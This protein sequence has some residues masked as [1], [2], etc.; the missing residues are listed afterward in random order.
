MRI[1]TRVSGAVSGSRCGQSGAGSRWTRRVAGT[2]VAILALSVAGCAGGRGER[3]SREREKAKVGGVVLE[4]ASEAAWSDGLESTAGLQPLRRAMPGTILMGRVSEILHKEGDRVKAGEVLA[5]IESRDVQARLAQ[6]EAAVSAARAQ[7]LNARL[8]RDRIQRLHEHNATSQK[9]LDDANAGCE[10]AEAGLRAAEEGVEAA[11]IRVGYSNITAPF[12]GVV[13]ERHVEAGDTASPGMPLFVVEDTRKLK[14]EAS[15]PESWLDK[16][17]VG[18]E[19][20]VVVDAAGG[21]VRRGTISEILPSVDP[22]TRTFTLRVLLDNEDGALRSGLFARLR[23]GGASRQAL[24]V[25]ESSL[26]RRGPLAGIFVVDEAG[27]AHLR[28]ITLGGTR[29]GRVEVLTG[30]KDGERYIVAPPPELEDGMQV[31]AK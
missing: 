31:E 8:T 10:A 7:A 19:T 23:I 25:P 27:S 15:V 22:R 1:Q 21:L 9:S 13:A 20:E 26:V 28:W 3:V 6:A 30:L 29:A 12:A 4:R 24:A 5:R 2:G 18:S 11:K 16:I 17:R 14:L